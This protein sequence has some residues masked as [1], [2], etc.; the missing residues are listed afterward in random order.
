MQNKRFNDRRFLM[1][2]VKFLLFLIIG[3]GLAFASGCDDSS[4]SGSSTSAGTGTLSVHMTD[5]PANSLDA[6]YVTIDEVAVHKAEDDE[7]DDNGRQESREDDG[8]WEVVASPQK[9]FNLLELVNG[10][11]AELGTSELEAGHYTQMRLMLGEN[12]DASLNINNETHMHANY[13]IKKDD[14]EQKEL[15]I[16]SGYQTGIKLV[17]GFDMATGQSTELLLDFDASR[18]VVLRGNEASNN[19]YL[20]K[21]TIK[22]VESGSYPMIQGMVTDDAQDPASLPDVWV[23]AQQIDADGRPEIIT[24]TLTADEEGETGAYQMYLPTGTYYIVAY[25]KNGDAT[26]YGPACHIIEAAEPNAVYGVD[27]EL[28]SSETGDIQVDVVLPE[29]SDT[30]NIRVLKTAPCSDT[31]EQIVIASE[32]IEGSGEYTFSVPGSETG[33]GADYT[34]EAAHEDSVKSQ[35]VQVY[36]I[37]S[38]DAAQAGFSFP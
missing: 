12:P 30:A 31:G 19:G 5:A 20:L 10:A 1:K 17:H 18:S 24:S 11:M 7:S 8:S 36:A 23:S 22:I 37:S 35:D 25:K 4:S 14:S 34:V 6:V 21:P 9:T 3:V 32:T 13:V 15:F 28:G 2:S 33:T 16:P 38:G 26:A 29:D 27:F